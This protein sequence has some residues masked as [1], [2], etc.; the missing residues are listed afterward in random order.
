MFSRTSTLIASALLLSLAACGGDEP[1]SGPACV[2]G[3]MSI[4]D[5]MTDPCPQDNAQCVAI[6]GK[7]IA[8]CM[9]GQWSDVCKCIPPASTLPQQA[10]TMAPNAVCGDGMVT[11]PTEAC[12]GMNLNGATC[13]KLGYAGGGTLACNPT[14]C[15]YDTIMCRMT[16]ATQPS[17]G[18]SGGTAGSGT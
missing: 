13:E 11:M 10:A 8:T 5:S 2:D 7:A 12:D 15:M 9:G 16:V 4:P 3:E 17:A 18:T 6:G 1:A 14:N